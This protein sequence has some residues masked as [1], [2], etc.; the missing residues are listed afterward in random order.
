MNVDEFMN[1]IREFDFRRRIT[2]VH[3]HHTCIPNRTAFDGAKT[4]EGIRWLH[5]E[6]YGWDDIAEHITID[7]KGYIWTGRDWNVPP[8]SAR[9]FNGDEKEGPFM[10]ELVGDFD[11]GRDSL[12]G[13]Q[14]SSAI[15]VVAC[16]QTRFNLAPESL[17]FHN[18]MSTFKT[19][20]GTSICYE[21]FLEEVRAYLNSSR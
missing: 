7:P 3:M 13:V 10:F 6:V 12:D 15:S 4:I 2:G 21:A 19:C 11:E 9:G 18:Q 17:R 14:R 8:A 16:L 1:Q 20:P 5:T